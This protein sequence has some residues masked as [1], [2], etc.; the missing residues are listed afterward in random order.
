LTKRRSGAF[1]EEACWGSI[2]E[3]KTIPDNSLVMGAPGKAVREVTA[4]HIARMRESA[5][6]YVHN[7]ACYRREL[8]ADDA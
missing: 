2:L 5:E 6:Q 8:C 7:S 3:G 1:G 4:D